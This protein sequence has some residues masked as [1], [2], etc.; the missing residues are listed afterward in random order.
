MDLEGS[1]EKILASDHEFGDAFYDVFFEQ[2][3]EAKEF[4]QKT[5]MR[6]QALMLSVSLRLVG[7]YHKR[8]SAAIGHYLKI[9][10]TR[11]ADRTIPPE[12]YPPWRDSLLVTLETFLGDDWNS[13]LSD[14][15]RAA[16]D[17]INQVMFKGYDERTGL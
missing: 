3:P 12:M 15:W 2:C 10:G 7:D 14:E 16:I 4:F 5:N 9:L 8:G 17:A 11:H 13:S 1:L 6:A